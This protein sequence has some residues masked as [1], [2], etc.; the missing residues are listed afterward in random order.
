MAAGDSIVS[1]CNIALIALGEDP[2]GALTDNNKRARTCNARY[3]DVRRAVL[4]RFPW[5]CAKRRAAVPALTAAPA[6]GWSTAFAM[7]ANFLR[8]I[9]LPDFD[10]PRY[11]MEG[12]DTYGNVL[13]CDYGAPL[14][15]SYVCDLQDPTKFSPSLV[16]ALAYELASEIGMPLVQNLQKVQLMLS[17]M[18]GKQSSARVTSSQQG[19][20]DEMDIDVLLRSRT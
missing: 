12:D 19:Q 20:V 16:H 4:E 3:D 11:E 10:K 2:I 15:I 9:D 14:N 7:P 8:V 1:I 6:F 13:L 17:I 5:N 18:E